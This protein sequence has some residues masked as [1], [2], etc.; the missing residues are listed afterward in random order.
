MDEKSLTKRQLNTLFEELQEAGETKLKDAYSKVKKTNHQLETLTLQ[1]KKY[2]VKQFTKIGLRTDAEKVFKITISKYSSKSRPKYSYSLNKHLPSRK[3]RNDISDLKRPCNLS[4][5]NKTKFLDIPLEIEIG[6]NSKC[7]SILSEEAKKYLLNRLRHSKH[8]D[9]R[10]LITPKQYDSNCYFNTMLVILFISDLGREFFYFFRHLMIVGELENGDEIP[11][12]LHILF[13]VF[14]YFIECFFSGRPEAIDDLDTNVLIKAIHDKLGP[15]EYFADVDAESNVVHYLTEMLDYLCIGSINIERFNADYLNPETD[16]SINDPPHI[17]ILFC[18][19]S[20]SYK[21]KQTLR[22]KKHVYKL[23]AASVLSFEGSPHFCA[24]I[25]CN[26]EEYIFDG[27]SHSR[28]HKMKW[29][30]LKDETFSFKPDENIKWNLF[31]SEV[32]LF[33]YRVM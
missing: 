20:S 8:L 13:S 32:F 30:T 23:D 22:I 27:N 28:L 3:S 10:K 4:I 12:E 29:K 2:L 18:D 24:C 1:D 33:Y 21:M 9:L 25:T 17:I 14:N 26:G 7:V 15:S 16:Y 11:E 5:F 6:D 31:L 19:G